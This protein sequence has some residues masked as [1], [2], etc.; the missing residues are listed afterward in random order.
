MSSCEE[1]PFAELSVSTI[2]HP[3]EVTQSGFY[4]YFDSKCSVLAQIL[5]E[6]AEE[7]E[8]FT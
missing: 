3:A 4:F 6:V 8:E 1:R 2:S 7:L 5:A